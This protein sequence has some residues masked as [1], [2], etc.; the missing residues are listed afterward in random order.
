MDVLFLAIILETLNVEIVVTLCK[1]LPVS[2]F[3]HF[4][5]QT[6]Q[7]HFRHGGADEGGFSGGV[8][9]GANGP[10]HYDRFWSNIYQK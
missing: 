1:F 2:F 7:S 10:S 9:D 5:H 8:S 3:F 6:V 4:M